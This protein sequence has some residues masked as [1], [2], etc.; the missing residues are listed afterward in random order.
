VSSDLEDTLSVQSPAALIVTAEPDSAETYVPGVTSGASMDPHMWPAM[1]PVSTPA[2]VSSAV[3][4][5]GPSA[6]PAAPATRAFHGFRI[7]SSAV[8]LL[9]AIAYIGRRPSAPRVVRG[10]KLRLVR[11]QSPM[12]EVSSTHLEVRQLGSTVVVQDLNSTNGTRV[13][14]P[15]LPVQILRP[16]ES[17]VVTAGTLIDIGD[18]N[19]V[20]IL[21]P[22]EPS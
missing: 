19:I 5:T 18:R 17:L 11:V 3:P 15:G 6:G 14:V 21:P 12:R 9:D 8:V 2:A 4:S 16:G 10:G 7:G 1:E 22:E 13:G 20:E